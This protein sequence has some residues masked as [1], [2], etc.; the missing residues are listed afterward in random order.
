MK[1]T[2]LLIMLTLIIG[3]A[4]TK[5]TVKE[6]TVLPPDFEGKISQTEID[7]LTKTYFFGR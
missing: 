7:Y 4:E 2:L 6:K 1:K 5:K 3:C